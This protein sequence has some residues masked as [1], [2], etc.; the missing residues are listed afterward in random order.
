M[1]HAIRPYG[2]DW[3][4][5][6]E[7]MRRGAFRVPEQLSFKDRRVLQASHGGRVHQLDRVEG[8]R[9]IDTLGDEY[10]LATIQIVDRGSRNVHVPESFQQPARWAKKRILEPYVEPGREFLDARARKEAPTA[11]FDN[12]MFALPYFTDQ[13]RLAGGTRGVGQW[14]GGQ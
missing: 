13:M 12:F 1:P 4:R 5:T 8:T 9:V 11:V 10:K 7:V 6:A 14:G 3:W 2:L